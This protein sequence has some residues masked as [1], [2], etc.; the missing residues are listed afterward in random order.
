VERLLAMYRVSSSALAVVLLV[1][2]N[3]VPLAG[4]L[5]WD[6]DLW[7]ILVLYWIENGIV[8]AFNVLKILS[9]RGPSLPGTSRVRFNG[10]PIEAVARG[11]IALFFM[12]HY[13]GFWAGHGLFV[14]LFLPLMGG[15]GF[16]SGVELGHDG[17]FNLGFAPFPSAGPDW[18]LVGLGA[19]GLAV[20]HGASFAFNYLGRGEYRSASP[21]QLMLAP[22]GRLV[23]LHVTIIFGA[24]V[25]VWI[26]SPVGSLV[27]LVVLKTLLDLAFHL[28]EHRHV[29]AGGTAA[30]AS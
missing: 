22:Y 20:S 6:W 27:V 4:V 23:I 18:T 9:A 28:R 13:G 3:L 1:A 25:S 2:V 12:V 15:I 24:M 17:S 19:V 10:R 29:A 30:T 21:A 16:G 26:G 7:S 8:G 14:L 11:P 5:W